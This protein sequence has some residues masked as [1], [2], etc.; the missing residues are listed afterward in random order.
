MAEQIDLFPYEAPE[1]KPAKMRDVGE[2]KAV[3]KADQ[4][5]LMDL[6]EPTVKEKERA[7]EKAEEAKELKE[8]AEAKKTEDTKRSNLAQRPMISPKGNVFKGATSGGGGGMSPKSG[9][10]KKPEYKAGGK[11]SSASKRADG[12]AIRGKTRA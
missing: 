9:L 11:V 1:P 8:R 2:G 3:S 4:A 7:K 5:K 10:N 12:I 6:P